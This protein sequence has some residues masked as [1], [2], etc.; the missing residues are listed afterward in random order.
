MPRNSPSY[1]S[2]RKPHHGT[3]LRFSLY[4]IYTSLS[5]GKVFIK[6]PGN[7]KDAN[8]VHQNQDRGDLFYFFWC[9][10]VLDQSI[11]GRTGWCSFGV[12]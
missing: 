7:L 11:K 8:D 4:S 5:I 10:P 3:P 2:T 12:A 1:G 6:I 9:F